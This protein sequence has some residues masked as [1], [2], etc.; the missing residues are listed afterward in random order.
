MSTAKIL[1][2][3]ESE[4]VFRH[5]EEE[6]EVR[7]NVVLDSGQCA[8]NRSVH[9]AALQNMA[10]R[11]YRLHGCKQRK[12]ARQIRNETMDSLGCKAYVERQTI[13]GRQFSRDCVHDQL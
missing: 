6:S 5:F 1:I 11:L 9:V 10:S 7:D 13:L 2:F 12:T 4:G 8:G 3:F